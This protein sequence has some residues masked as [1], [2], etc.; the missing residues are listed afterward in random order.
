MEK[1][2]VRFPPSPTG[3]LHIGGART[4]LFNW[5]FARKHNGVFILRIEDTDVE[6]STQEAV[7]EILEGLRWMGIDWDEGPYFQSQ[8]VQ[9]HRSVAMELLERGWAYRCFCTREQLEARRMEAIRQKRSYRYEG[10]CR[11]IP[12]E[13]SEKRAREGEPHIIRFKVPRDGGAVHWEDAVFG[14]EKKDH[15]DIEDFVI[16]RSNGMPVYLLSN[17]VDDHRDGVTHVIR[18]QDHR[19]NTPKQVLMYRAMG[20]SVPNFAHISLTLDPKKRKISKRVHGEVVTVRFY[21]ERGFLPWAFCNFIA[22]LGWSPGGDREIFSREELME[23][24]SLERLSKVNSTFNYDPDNPRFFTD[25]KAISINAHYIRN[26]PLDELLP[27]VEEE[28]K[29]EGLW[30]SELEGPK[31]QWFRETVD[32]IRVRFTTLKDFSS[33]G[34]PYFSDEYPIE[35][36]AM[37]KNLKAH[38]NLPRWLVELADRIERMESFDL[39]SSER[40]IRDAA[41]QWG[42]KAGVIINGIRAAVTGQ[43]VGPGLFDVLVT[44]GQERVVRRLRRIAR[45]LKEQERDNHSAGED[46]GIDPTA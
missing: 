18:G 7:D 15:E 28:L 11:Q 36:K 40:V 3:Y 31:H 27:Y 30:S 44:I 19:A 46:H 5:L 17:M 22:L 42:V 45:I 23:M 16:V 41:A 21:R 34:R 8:Y 1:V 26:M 4:A 35:E 24:F 29:S 43:T 33:L 25:P 20:W 13:L 6:R 2:R 39:E 12:Q 10:T 14:H 32:L 9:E 37:E 38:P